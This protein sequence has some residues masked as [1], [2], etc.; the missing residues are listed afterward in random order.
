[1]KTLKTLALATAVSA[2]LLGSVGVMAANQGSLG[3]NS[4]GDFD[5]TL[6]HASGVRIWGLEDFTFDTNGDDSTLQSS[7]KD[8]CIFTNDATSSTDG[9]YDIIATG[10]SLTLSNGVPADALVY[11]VEFKDSNSST[12]S[13]NTLIDNGAISAQVG[14][15]N[16]GNLFDQPNP[17][18]DTCSAPNANVK[19]TI[20]P[21]GAP[22]GTYTAQVFLT[23]SPN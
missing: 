14:S 10:S 20:D 3:A 4:N 5:I 23:V 21:D 22:S 7:N 11:K 18:I 9:Q 13:Y 15:L 12:G 17:A 16:A 1:M 2:G 8:L 19:V 6:V